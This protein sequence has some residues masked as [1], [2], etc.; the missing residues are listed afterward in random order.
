MKTVSVD[1]KIPDGH[2]VAEVSMIWPGYDVSPNDAVGKMLVKTKATK[3]FLI[4]GVP[5]DWPEWLV[6]DW[7][8]KDASGHIFGYYGDPPTR[9]LSS[10]WIVDGNAKCGLVFGTALTIPGPWE[11]SLREN[12]RRK[13]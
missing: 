1:I 5:S 4:N 6:C 2:E 12:P 3:P 7:V 11:Q 8:A 13:K 10:S 9:M